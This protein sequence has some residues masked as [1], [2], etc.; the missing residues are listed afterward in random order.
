MTNNEE[1]IL[2]AFAYLVIVVRWFIVINAFHKDVL[3]VNHSYQYKDHFVFKTLLVARAIILASIAPLVAFI[4][5]SY[6]NQLFNGVSV[7]A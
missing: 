2:A 1:C 5:P 6:F 7:K 3:A 4:R